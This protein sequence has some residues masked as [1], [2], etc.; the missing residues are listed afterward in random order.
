MK[1]DTQL[2]QRAFLCSALLCSALLSS[3]GSSDAE[4][5]ESKSKLLARVGESA[6]YEEQVGGIGKGFP[7]EDSTALMQQYIRQWVEEELLLADAEEVLASDAGLQR[8]LQA[9]KRQLL[10]EKQQQ[11]YLSEKLDTT[12]GEEQLA[13]YYAKHKE[14]FRQGIEWVRCHFVRIDKSDSEAE[15]LKK[16]FREKTDGN[17]QRLREYYRD[18][19]ENSSFILNE[20]A[21]IRLTRLALEYPKKGEELDVKNLKRREYI[22]V[23]DKNYYYLLHSFEYRGKDEPSPL[24]ALEANLR[25]S[26]IEERKNELLQGYREELYQE[27]KEASRFTLY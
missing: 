19:R 6:L 25:S 11:R 9:Y 20:D 24:R 26:I 10:K 23:E 4:T 2:R 1:K 5:S 27:A 7:P 21:W 16:W 14:Q 8:E 17:L 22:E 3:C 13:E 18:N 15:Q 12:V